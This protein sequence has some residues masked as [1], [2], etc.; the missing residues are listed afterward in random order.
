MISRRDLL[1]DGRVIVVLPIGS[2]REFYTLT[3]E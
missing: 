3:A 2:G 1:K